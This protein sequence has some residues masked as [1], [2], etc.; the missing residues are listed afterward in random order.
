MWRVLFFLASLTLRN[1]LR[2]VHTVRILSLSVWSGF[3]YMAVLRFLSSPPMNI[4]C[5]VCND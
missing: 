2:F 5:C 3:H 1:I 4:C